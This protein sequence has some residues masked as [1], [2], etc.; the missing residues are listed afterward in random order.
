[1][2]PVSFLLLAWLECVQTT[3]S[4]RW[5]TGVGV[6]VVL[7]ILGWRVLREQPT[8]LA[9]QS[10]HLFFAMWALGGI[11]ALVCATDA[12]GRLDRSRSRHLVDLAPASAVTLQ[13]TRF[14]GTTFA[15]WTAS[16][17]ASLVAWLLFLGTETAR[18][19]AQGVLLGWI[20]A[21]LPLTAMGA[22]LGVLLRSA[23]SNDGVALAV[24]IPIT[25]SASIHVAFAQWP[26]EVLTYWTEAHGLLIPLPV[27]LRDAASWLGAALLFF[28]VALLLS[29]PVAFRTPR[30]LALGR[31][32][33]ITAA[34]WRAA[35]TFRTLVREAL[36]WNGAAALLFVGL[37][38]AAGGGR[39]LLQVAPSL[40]NRSP[41]T[42]ALDPAG[43]GDSVLRPPRIHSRDLRVEFAP[44]DLLHVTLELSSGTAHEQ[45]LAGLRF[46]HSMQIV[47]VRPSE[48]T[49]ELLEESA[50]SGGDAVLRFD[51]PLHPRSQRSVV[52]TLR[53][54]PDAWRAF[55]HTRHPRYATFERLGEWYG[56][57][58]RYDYRLQRGDRMLRAP[59]PFRVAIPSASGRTWFAGNARTVSEGGAAVVVQPR[60]DV[61]APLFSAEMAI[62]ASGQLG[63][64]G[65]RGSA[66]AADG[67]PRLALQW[68]MLPEHRDVAE[69]L[70]VMTAPAF[71]RAARLVAAEGETLTL[72][73]TPFADP[74]NPFTLRP[75]AVRQFSLHF[76]DLE[77][78]DD[79]LAR[80]AEQLI[81]QALR[82]TIETRFAE[83]FDR[84]EP[85]ALF[86]EWRQYLFAHGLNH[87][88]LARFARRNVDFDLVPWAWIARREGLRP[89]D[90]AAANERDF[91]GPLPALDDGRFQTGARL[92]LRA[93]HHMLRG[94]LGDTAYATLVGD[95]FREGG[96][97]TVE[98]LQAEAERLHG[99]SL[100]TFFREWTEKGVLPDYRVVSAEV[101]LSRDG[102]GDRRYVTTARVSNRGT[103][104]IGVPI[105]LV[106]D[107]ATLRE[108]HPIPSGEEVEVRFES[109]D[110]PL[111]IEVDPEGWIAQK[112]PFD[113]RTGTRRPA[114][115]ALRTIR[116]EP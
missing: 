61:P 104:S 99:E 17:V 85:A 50:P 42:G 55:A 1:M 23:I 87:G 9:P 51:P 74:L 115:L 92:R 101:V 59:A 110:R 45:S 111:W 26:R 36:S 106:T 10:P 72:V 64:V 38:V 80:E 15:A 97:L 25:I 112:A 68:I 52:F 48:G 54:R 20:A 86:E 46:G 37:G 81:A 14:V 12:I 93:F 3:R 56:E 21:G 4:A 35:A 98:R 7:S 76:D 34:I 67:A 108:R 44:E 102:G 69:S 2:R 5:R 70:D 11:L 32:G 62:V 13:G 100:E 109:R 16:G 30:S 95:L 18:L 22:S 75:R 29:R 49:V 84:A 19:P 107:G 6:L 58:L 41:V 28:G 27:V 89:F 105:H 63:T 96:E 94:K 53:P 57:P 40:P 43:L 8:T 60:P 82:G 103:G 91:E 33:I 39:F 73:E 78:S 90:I 77:L 66:Q 79:E 83:R 71:R 47:E 113:E 88:Q 31:G 116:E 114:R 65:Q 24:G